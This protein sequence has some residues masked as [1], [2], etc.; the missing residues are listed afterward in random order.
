MK[1]LKDKLFSKKGIIIILSIV[2]VLIIVLVLA[3]SGDKKTEESTIIL[4]CKAN[5]DNEYATIALNSG[6][7]SENDQLIYF[8]KLTFVNI[9]GNESI[10]TIARAMFNFEEYDLDEHPDLIKY[11]DTTDGFIGDF[12]MI[13]SNYSDEERKELIGTTETTVTGIKSFLEGNDLSCVEY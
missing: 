11:T 10:K 7:K 12:E 8:Q 5:Y 6:I 2:V 3:L 13:L 9:S 4:D 1:N